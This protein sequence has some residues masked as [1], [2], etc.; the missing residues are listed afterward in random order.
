[1]KI[2]GY[3][4]VGATLAAALLAA[5]VEAR[6]AASSKVALQRLSGTYASLAPEDWGRGTFGT[7]KF[8]FRNGRW[9]LDFALALDPAMANKVFA[10]RTR[11][12]YVVGA[13]SAVAPGAFNAVFREDAKYVTLIAGDPKLAQAFGLAGCG[14]VAGVEKDISLTGCA[15]WKPVSACAEDHDLLMLDSSGGLRFGVR[16]A[17]NDMCT[18]DKRPIKLL[19]AVVKR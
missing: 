2:K 12:S 5:T 15:S 10:F 3:L 8:T 1:M 6:P 9:T 18:A 7:R 17:D 16:P 19:P 13:R 11:G 4:A 14:L